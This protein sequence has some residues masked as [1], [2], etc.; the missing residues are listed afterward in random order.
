MDAP[1]ESRSVARN[2]AVVLHRRVALVLL[3]IFVLRGRHAACQWQIALRYALTCKSLRANRSRDAIE[4]SLRRHHRSGSG[5][6]RLLLLLLRRMSDCRRARMLLCFLT[7]AKAA[8]RAVREAHHR[9]PCSRKRPV[10]GSDKH[11][12]RAVILQDWS[13]ARRTRDAGGRTRHCVVKITG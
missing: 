6:A 4:A 12:F 11:S 2:L 13:R 8:R 3:C 10:V 1:K 5:L 7:D 9:Y